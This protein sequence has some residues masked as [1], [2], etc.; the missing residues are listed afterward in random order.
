MSA[1]RVCQLPLQLGVVG[2]EG[3]RDG[4]QHD[5]R[6]AAST[7]RAAAMRTGGP[8]ANAADPGVDAPRASGPPPNPF[9]RTNS[10][11]RRRRRKGVNL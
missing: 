1:S 9:L 5:K 6:A 4:T 3:E 2:D 8:E 7:C 11:A 10:E